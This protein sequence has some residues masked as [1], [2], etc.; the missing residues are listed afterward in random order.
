MMRPKAHVI[1]KDAQLIMEGLLSR[2]WN[3]QSLNPD[4]TLD[5]RV[6]IFEGGDPTGKRVHVQL[7]GSRNHRVKRGSISFRMD[8]KHVKYYIDKHREPVF[9][10]LVDVTN[11][12]GWWLF[13]Q[14]Y[15]SMALDYP[16]W[17]EQKTIAVHVPELNDMSNQRLFSEAILA[18]ES[19]MDARSSTSITQAVKATREDLE[20]KDGRFKIDVSLIEGREHY[21][22]TPKEN[23]NFSIRSSKSDEA[24]VKKMRDLFEKG[25]SVNFGPNEVIFEGMPLLQSVHEHGGTV[26]IGEPKPARVSMIALGKSGAELARIDGISG[27]VVGGAKEKRFSG[28]LAGG[29]IGLHITVTRYGATESHGGFKFR[30][31]LEAW[32]GVSL[33][34]LENISAIHSLLESHG[35]PRRFRLDMRNDS[36]TIVT[37]GTITA[38][39]EMEAMLDTFYGF[40]DGVVKCQRIMRHFGHDPK[41]TS[42]MS[43][44]DLELINRVYGMLFEDGYSY[45]SHNQAVSVTMSPAAS[46]VKRLAGSGP[47]SLNLMSDLDVELFGQRLSV[48]RVRTVFT[49]MSLVEKVEVLENELQSGK[50]ELE[51]SWRGTSSTTATNTLQ[52][53]EEM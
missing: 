18:A 2:E 24:V 39:D 4:Y 35:T 27:E 51:V 26:T 53:E 37:L 16:D 14:G 47:L 23:V 28:C 6:E 3:V 15:A 46:E 45:P 1:D 41:F 42:K 30:L 29:L 22:L 32:Q 52:P 17:R 11:R 9:L 49:N 38:T 10:V 7:K 40:L 33:S 25:V 19:F 36:T 48:G 13:M 8:V 34:N 44:E 12:R 5:Y 20:R 50:K 31:N 21:L 43:M